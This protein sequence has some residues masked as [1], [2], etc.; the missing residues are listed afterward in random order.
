[1]PRGDPAPRSATQLRAELT[2]LERHLA[3]APP[4]APGPVRETLQAR[5]DALQRA[6]A[7]AAE[8]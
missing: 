6:L 3:E 4:H 8:R 2:D 7:A 1:M 5:R